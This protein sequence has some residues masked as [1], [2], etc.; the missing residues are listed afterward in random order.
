MA[1]KGGESFTREGKG[2]TKPKSTIVIGEQRD[3]KEA[4]ET[5]KGGEGTR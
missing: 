2:F 4:G 1:R 3:L 5:D